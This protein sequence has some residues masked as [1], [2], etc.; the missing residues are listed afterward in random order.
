M[1]NNP[2]IEALD[3]LKLPTL[4]TKSDIKRQ[5]RHLAK[6][7]HPDRG[8]SDS[9]MEKINNA[10]SILIKYVDGFRYS[11]SEEEIHHQFPEDFHTSKFRP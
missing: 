6:I 2:I 4:I 10:Y 9:E 11:F 8:G 1:T 7:L 3:T 5:Y